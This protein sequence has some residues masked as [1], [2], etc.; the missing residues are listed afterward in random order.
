MINSALTF[1]NAPSA[2]STSTS[3][4]AMGYIALVFGRC[5]CLR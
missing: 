3:T 1:F 5:V 2:C 4:S